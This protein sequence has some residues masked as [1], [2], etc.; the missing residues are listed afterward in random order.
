[1]LSSY[2]RY[3][4]PNN[5]QHVDDVINLLAKKPYVAVP[6][7]F[8]RN[9]KIKT[10]N[11]YFTNHTCNELLSYWHYYYRHPTL[12]YFLQKWAIHGKLILFILCIILVLI[13]YLKFFKRNVG[14]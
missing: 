11:L 9:Y 10:S 8:C 5:I 12:I 6:L 3:I 13:I 7:L 4:Q 1:M 14:V 2:K